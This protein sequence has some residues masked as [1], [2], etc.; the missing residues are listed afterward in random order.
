VCEERSLAAE[1]VAGRPPGA[2]GPRAAPG[3]RALGLDLGSRRIGVALSDSDGVLATP[4]EVI[5]RQGDERRDHARIV[6]LADEVGAAVVVVGLP[7]SLDGSAGPA[8]RATMSEVARLAEVAG[9]PVETFDERLSTV[10][11]HRSLRA[12]GVGGRAR[13]R[14]VDQVAAAVMLQAWLDAGAQRQRERGSR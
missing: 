5:P 4:Y 8:A 1:P 3:R 14:V 9:R 11:A 12:N 10:S 7:L 2:D 13:R 6:E